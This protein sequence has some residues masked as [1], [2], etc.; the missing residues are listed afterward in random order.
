MDAS[1]HI[2]F[3]WSTCLNIHILSRVAVTNIL[4]ASA[5]VLVPAATVTPP[6]EPASLTMSAHAGSTSSVTEEP[7]AVEMEELDMFSSGY[8]TL[9]PEPTTESPVTSELDIALLST[10]NKYKGACDRNQCVTIYST[11]PF[12][13]T[14]CWKAC[15][16][17]GAKVWNYWSTGSCECRSSCCRRPTGHKKPL[18]IPESK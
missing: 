4:L 3:H 5:V 13:R 10:F 2:H 18:Y 17:L 14:S 15:D 7:T 8:P 9:P 12:T 1:N 11:S 6:T 16:A